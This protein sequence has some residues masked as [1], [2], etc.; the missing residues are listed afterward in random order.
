MTKR[1]KKYHKYCK[2]KRWANKLFINLFKEH[3]AVVCRPFYHVG[4]Y[5]NNM[6]FESAVTG[7]PITKIPS[8]EWIHGYMGTKNMDYKSIG[9]MMPPPKEDYHPYLDYLRER[10]YGYQFR[11]MT[12]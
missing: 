11:Y 1:E 4:S 6:L 8:G 3:E 2:H 9:L 5:E 10:I 7:L 12:F